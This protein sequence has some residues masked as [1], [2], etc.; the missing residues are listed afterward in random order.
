MI[1]RLPAVYSIHYTVY[2][3]LTGK[4]NRLRTDQLTDQWK[5]GSENKKFSMMC[6]AQIAMCNNAQ[7]TMCN[8]QITLRFFW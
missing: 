8:A 2:T 1:T 6:N 5:N 7:T 3:L 4:N